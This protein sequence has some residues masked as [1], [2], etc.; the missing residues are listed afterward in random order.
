V[1][2]TDTRKPLPDRDDPDHGFFW[3]G[4]DRDQLHVKQCADCSR[5]HWPPR[6]GCPHCGS[7]QVDWCQVGTAGKL[8]SWT[9]VHRSLTPG[10]GAA[11]PYAVVLVE[12]DEAP[13]VR[14]IGNLV[15][16]T[17]GELA[18]DLP[19]Q[20]VFVPAEDGSVKLVHWRP[21]QP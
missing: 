1:T 18:A 20:A 2:P 11:T 9:V 10:F 4:T 15:H 3:Q 16:G 21:V 17:P 8:F 7:A 19:M 14:M 12:L 5:F 13:G 6:L